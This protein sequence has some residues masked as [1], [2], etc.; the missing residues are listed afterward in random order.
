MMFLIPTSLQFNC[1]SFLVFTIPHSIDKRLFQ[2]HVRSHDAVAKAE[3]DED[4]NETQSR[5]RKITIDFCSVLVCSAVL[6]PCY[7]YICLSWMVILVSVCLWRYLCLSIC[8][9]LG[10][11]TNKLEF[12]LECHRNNNST[13]PPWTHKS[14]K[15][16][17][18]STWGLKFICFPESRSLPSMAVGV[19]SKLPPPPTHNELTEQLKV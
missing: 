18:I 19:K 1:I 8:P 3:D 2:S 4:L 10:L 5:G 17:Y 6:S 16:N 15:F 12:E 9:L 7:Y 11:S 14:H 13:P